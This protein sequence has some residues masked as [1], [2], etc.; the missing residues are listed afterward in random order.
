MTEDDAD[1]ETLRAE[2]ET[3]WREHREFALKLSRR[4][5]FF[6][7]RRR[8]ESQDVLQEAFECAWRLYPEKRSRLRQ[9]PDACRPW[10][11]AI[12]KNQIRELRRF[13]GREKRRTDREVSL[14]SHVENIID[15]VGPSPESR[16]LSSE[17]R[18][19]VRQTVAKLP[20]RQREVVEL[21]YLRRLSVNEAAERMG[22]TPEATRVLLSTTLK[23]L[24]KELRRRGLGELGDGAV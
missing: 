9:N 22:K 20:G 5:L 11:A 16:L 2:F 13:H 4:R 10:L 19:Q 15:G 21:V 23:R 8:E 17:C 1:D 12:L 7:L 3:L 6:A 24:G 18:E 14:G